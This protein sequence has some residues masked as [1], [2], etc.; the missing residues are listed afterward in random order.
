MAMSEVVTTTELEEGEAG[1]A[2]PNGAPRR[3]WIRTTVGIGR[4]LLIVGAFCG[5]YELLRT[6][7]VQ[8]GAQAAAHSLSVAHL[9]SQLGIFH[10]ASIQHLFLHAP[11][12]VKFFNLYYGG[13]HFLVP[14]LAL[15][16]LVIRHRESYARARTTLAVTTGVGFL[17]FWLFPVAPPRLLPPRFHIIDT[18]VTFHQSGHLEHSLIDSAGDIY[19][20]MPSLHVAWALWSTLVLYPVARHRA[21]KVALVAYP[22]LTTLVVVTTGNHFFLDAAVGSLLVS[23]VWFALPKA[24]DLRRH[25]FHDP[26]HV[27][28]SV[29]RR[30]AE[31]FGSAPVPALNSAHS[32][33]RQ[34]ESPGHYDHAGDHALPRYGDIGEGNRGRATRASQKAVGHL[35]T[36][37][38]PRPPDFEQLPT[39]EAFERLAKPSDDDLNP[40]EDTPLA[41]TKTP[42]RAANERPRRSRGQEDQMVSGVQKSD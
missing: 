35:L 34:N 29:N 33:E 16:W 20:A 6:D 18:L 17:I 14:A 7:V 32:V 37:Y 10:E 25:Y 36:A 8:D 22:I 15:T 41:R 13:T 1:P 28:M 9:E 11:D 2:D 19:A 39:S 21:V 24:A 38:G 23:L 3:S 26:A 30:F 42:F 4:E 31:L 12:I 40:S 5:L 27:G